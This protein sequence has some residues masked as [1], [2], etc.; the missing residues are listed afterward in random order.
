MN[1][2]KINKQANK[3]TVKTNRS[4]LVKE[5]DR[6]FSLF[7][8]ARDKKSVL[9]GSTENLVCS[10]VFSRVSF[11]TR[12]NEKNCYAMTNGE[13]LR[14]EYY[15]AYI[16]EWFIKKYGLKEFEILH[17]ISHKPTKFK[18]GDLKMMII[19][20]KK[21]IQEIEDVKEERC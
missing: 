15:P 18:D 7:I 9:S 14:H 16:N 8:R 17:A 5:L 10:H 20:Y 4:K 21:K 1:R 11:S 19:M 6:V 3:V 2:T 13:N 12:W